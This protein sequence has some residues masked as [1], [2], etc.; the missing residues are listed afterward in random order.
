MC[1]FN[2][3]LLNKSNFLNNALV[4]TD[5]FH[6]PTKPSNAHYMQHLVEYEKPLLYEEYKKSGNVMQQP[7]D[8]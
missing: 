2:F 8:P 1:N 4:S 6:T 7:M 5:Y 3:D